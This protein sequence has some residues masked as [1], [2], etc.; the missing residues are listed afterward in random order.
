M[1]KNMPTSVAKKPPERHALDADVGVVGHVGAHRHE[2][3]RSQ[4][5]LAAV[6]HQNVHAQGGQRQDQERDQDGAEHVLVHQKRHADEGERDQCEDGP[7]V[8]RD[9]EDLLV[10]AVGGL[11]LTVFSVEHLWSSN[12]FL[13]TTRFA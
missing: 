7:A 3:P 5:D 13:A 8:L 9:R 12:N 2:G 1:P 6:A 10:G 11:E 4:R